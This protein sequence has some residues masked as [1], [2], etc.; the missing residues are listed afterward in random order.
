MLQN[1]QLGLPVSLDASPSKQVSRVGLLFLKESRTVCPP[2]IFIFHFS[3]LFLK[4]NG[5]TEGTTA[6]TV[7]LQGRNRP[8]V[9]GISDV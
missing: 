2:F 9:E 8:I 3:F 4:A 1:A 7:P 6:V 5:V